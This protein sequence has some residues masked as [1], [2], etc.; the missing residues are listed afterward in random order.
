MYVCGAVAM[1]MFAVLAFGNA[2]EW[3]DV[4]AGLICLGLAAALGY[5]ALRRPAV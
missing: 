4:V 2:S 5:R 1:L 3:F